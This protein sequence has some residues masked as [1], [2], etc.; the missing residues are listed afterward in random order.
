M[1]NIAR[2]AVSAGEVSYKEKRIIFPWPCQEKWESMEDKF[3]A[4]PEF[5]TFLVEKA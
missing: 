2:A 1:L 3:P 5:K 4:V